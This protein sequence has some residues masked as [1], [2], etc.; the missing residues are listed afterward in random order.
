MKSCL[1]W[2]PGEPNRSSSFVMP[3]SRTDRQQPRYAIALAW[4]GAMLLAA[5][6]CTAQAAPSCYRYGG[7]WENNIPN[8]LYL[9]FPTAADATFPNYPQTCGTPVSPAQPFNVSDLDSG[10]GTTA[11]LRDGVFDVVTDAYC[12]FNVQVKQSTTNPDSFGS[13]DPRRNVVAVGSDSGGCFGVAQNYAGQIDLGD[14]HPADHARVWGGSYPLGCGSASEG[15]LEGGNSTLSRW[16]NA[17]GS[18]GA[19]EA[20]HNYGLQHGDDSFIHTGEDNRFHHIMPSATLPGES[21]PV[22]D[23]TFRASKR[24]FSDT[25]FSVLAHNIGLVSQTMGNWDFVNPNVGNAS[26]LR[27]EVLSTASTLTLTYWWNGLWSP[28]SAPTVSGSLGTTVFQGTTY[29]IFH[30]T[31]NTGKAWEARNIPGTAQ[32][33]GL[34]PSGTV[35]HIGAEFNGSHYYDPDPYIIHEVVLL[36]GGGSPLPLQPRMAGYDN[37]AL[38]MVS[39]DFI[40][41][42]YSFGAPLILKNLTIHELPRKIT[43]DS[44]QFGMEMKTWDGQPVVPWKSTK[45]E[46]EFQLTKDGL[47]VPVRNLFKDGHNVFVVHGR[48]NPQDAS[49]GGAQENPD[50]PGSISVDLFPSTTVYVTATVVDPNTHY[51]DPKTGEDKVA[52]SLLFYQFA[53]KRER[54]PLTGQ[55]A[56]LIRLKVACTDLTTRQSLAA[57]VNENL[58]DCT[59]AGLSASVGDSINVIVKGVFNGERNAAGAV[60]LHGSVEGMKVQKVVCTNLTTR[61]SINAGLDESGNWNCQVENFSVKA[62]DTINVI[63]KGVIN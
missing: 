26:Q 11:Q 37:G 18:T 33:P 63:A 55:V 17:I 12:E 47:R 60:P 58:W 23:C 29:H 61:S 25:T 3:S 54:R 36:D 41:Q 14:T 30:V 27:M 1:A 9:Y 35:F 15:A 16:A 53:G 52:E 10:I 51:K 4:L 40:M 57:D 22:P 43:L 5:L 49:T 59:N 50:V 21:P 24:H 34:V 46:G 13:P 48:E 2:F 62:G 44:M 39:G 7:A 31:W 56:G 19:H 8:K 45:I 28:W 20:G 6:A 32:T 42:F 38:D